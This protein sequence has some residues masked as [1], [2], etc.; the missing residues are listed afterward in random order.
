MTN[1]FLTGATGFL[2]GELLVELAKREEVKSIYCLVRAQSDEWAYQRIAKVFALHGDAFDVEKI[3]PVTGELTDP[4]LA[5]R[6]LS[7]HRL[8]H[9]DTIIHTAANTSFSKIYD[10]SVEKVNIGGTHHLLKWAQGLKSLKTFAYVGTAA[11][12]GTTIKECV[13]TEDQSPDLTAEHLVKYSY[14]KMVGEIILRDYLPDDKILVV[15]PS[16]IMGDTRSWAPRSC[17]ILWALATLNHLRLF[18]M[19]P[20]SRIDIIPIDYAVRSILKLLFNTKRKY[21]VY[22]ISAGSSSWTTPELVTNAIKDSFPDK[23]D[24]RFVAKHL[25][26]FMRKWTK[27]GMTVDLHNP[28]YEHRNYLE[29]WIDHF[30]DNSKLRILFHAMEP[31]M[32][33]VELGQVFDNTRLMEDT[34]M[35]PSIPAHTY[36]SK[37]IDYIDAI[38]IFEGAVDY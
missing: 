32:N 24:F 19:N 13:V 38:N 28:L 27:N 35:G 11:I 15:R 20:K 31:Y 16:I 10:T 30:G 36:I 6:L 9:I 37:S 18:P 7:D 21:S 33:F 25:W 5:S 4:G 1:I 26:P 3:I 17:V 34:D 22:H 12:C 23:P 2:G 8:A 14:T 29:Y